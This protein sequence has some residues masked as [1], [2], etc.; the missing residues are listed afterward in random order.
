[1][2]RRPPRKRPKKKNHRNSGTQNPDPMIPKM[3]AYRVLSDELTR[4]K[5][6]KLNSVEG[7][8]VQAYLIDCISTTRSLIDPNL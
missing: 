1:M 5:S 3:I 8:A 2:S 7:E 6:I 4:L